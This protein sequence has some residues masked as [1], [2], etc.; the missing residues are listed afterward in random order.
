VH[1]YR[2]LKLIPLLLLSA[3]GGGGSSGGVVNPPP[4]PPPTQIIAGPGPNVAT[5]T[6]NAGPAN[7]INIPFVSVTICPHGSTTGCATVGGIEVD[8]GSSGLRIIQSALPAGF[9]QTL[10]QQEAGTVPIA[11][12]AV[13][14]DG[15]S[16]GGIRMADVTVSSETASNIPIQIIGDTSITSTV[17]SDCAASG[18]MEEDTV[19]TF[20]ANGVLGVSAFQQDCGNACVTS[21]SP[22]GQPFYYLCPSNGTCSNTTQPLDMQVPNPVVAFAMDNNGAIVELPSAT[23][24]AASATGALVFGIGT[25][26]NNGLGTAKVLTEDPN[27]GFVD[28][29]FQGTDYPDSYLDSGS[30]SLYFTDNTLSVCASNTAGS[31]F[32][33][34]NASL[35]ATITG[36][37]AVQVTASFSVADATTL[38]TDSPSGTVFPE[39]GAP[40]FAGNSSTFDF[41]LPYFYGRNVFTAIEGKNTP[42][43]MGPYLAY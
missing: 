14:A 7:S 38:F 11:E 32:Y 25:Q 43:G 17:P 23:D 33:C 22:G 36:V 28:I 15:Y 40:I 19:D 20:L 2:T 30:N 16:W 35:S 42:G 10:A 4:P 41:G 18:P 6:V 3:C 21:P 5:L 26:S 27:F 8:T 12:C 31:G 9:A 13:F 39:L 37:N 24:G 1:S 34:S 29:N